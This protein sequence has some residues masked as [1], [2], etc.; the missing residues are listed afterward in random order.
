[1]AQHIVVFD[2]SVLIPLILRASQSTR[3]FFR[4]DAAGWKIV[5]SPQ[6]FAEVEEKLRTKDSLR[7]WLQLT[8]DEID[9]FLNVGLPG[10]V[11]ST[12]GTI[13]LPGAVPDDPKD[14]MVIA[15]AVEAGASYLVTEDKHLLT[16][17]DYEGI[18]ILNRHDFAAE[19]DRLGVAE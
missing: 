6:L 15:A 11:Q 4:L 8:D 13:E 3:L 10:M 19:L 12:G 9:E 18:H 7:K 5:A 17:T 16:I 14:D 2:S 1:M